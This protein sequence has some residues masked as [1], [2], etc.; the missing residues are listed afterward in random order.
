MIFFAGVLDETTKTVNSRS[1]ALGLFI[2]VRAFRR[3]YKRS[4]LYP[5]GAYNRDERKCFEK[6]YSSA[7]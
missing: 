6:S 4:D 5:R 1:E 7:D 3:V 2:F